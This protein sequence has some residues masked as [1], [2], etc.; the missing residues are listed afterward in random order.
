MAMTGLATLWWIL[1]ELSMNN[2]DE[3]DVFLHMIPID[4]LKAPFKWAKGY[5]VQV[6]VK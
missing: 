3:S 2:L 5:E 4:I 6:C 1:K